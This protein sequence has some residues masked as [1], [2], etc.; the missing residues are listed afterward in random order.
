MLFSLVDF[1]ICNLCPV[2]EFYSGHSHLDS[3]DFAI[4]RIEL[5][6]K[7]DILSNIV[8]IRRYSRFFYQLLNINQ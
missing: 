5:K 3:L 1:L 4:V 8:L 7:C 6:L 2:S